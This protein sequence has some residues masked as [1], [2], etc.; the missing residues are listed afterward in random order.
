MPRTQ[1]REL[2]NWFTRTASE[3]IPDQLAAAYLR[4][5]AA[6]GD[7]IPGISDV[8]FYLIVHD[9]AIL[10]AS[11]RKILYERLHPMTQEANRRW[12]A[13][14]PS[15]RVVPF[16]HLRL[17][18]VGSYLTSLEAK[19]LL[20]SDVLAQVTKPSTTELSQFGHEELRRFLD[21]WARQDD[22]ATT[23]DSLSEM[24]ARKQYLVLKLAQTAL[25]SR[26]IISLR[27]QEV[28][29]VFRKEF[30]TLDSADVVEEANHLRE[31]GL[32]SS[33][34][35]ELRSFINE[36]DRFRL[37]LRESFSSRT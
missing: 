28:C 15:F 30:Y 31:N 6:R 20:G 1:L 26:G 29:V 7:N 18:N 24:A 10:N 3:S 5:S 8:D 23:F 19:I 22:D 34:E 27:K 36:A 14:K 33:H 17:N 13:E 11:A 9:S 37:V 16:S 25:F 35:S 2:T 21:F 4:G 32:Q 12:V